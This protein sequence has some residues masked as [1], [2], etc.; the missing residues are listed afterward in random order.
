MP[1]ITWKQAKRAGKYVDR[2]FGGDEDAALAAFDKIEDEEIKAVLIAFREWREAV[3]A[4]NGQRPQVG[5]SKRAKR[6]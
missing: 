2:H 4:L 5:E 3:R 6:G 1:R